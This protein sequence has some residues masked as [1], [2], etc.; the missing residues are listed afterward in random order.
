MKRYLT[1]EDGT[2]YEGQAFGGSSTSAGELV[3]TTG[4]TGYQETMTDDSYAGQLVI[5]TNPLLGNYGVSLADNEDLEPACAGVI[6]RQLARVTD[7]WRASESLDSFMQR[8][9]LPGISGI[10]TRELTQKLRTKGSM[11]ALITDEVLPAEKLPAELIQDQI[12]SFAAVKNQQ[13][14]YRIPGSGFTIVVVD[15]GAKQSILREL[16]KRDCNLVVVPSSSTAEQILSFA[17]DGVL[18]S[19]GPGDP[20]NYPDALPM[21][22]KIQ[23]KTVIFGICL[24]HQLFARANGAQTFKMKFGHRGFNHPVQEVAT[25]ETR[26]T[27]QNHGYAVDAA[28]LDQTLLTKTYV[29][30]NDQTVEGLRHKKFPAASVQ[31]HP[32]A[33][34]GPHDSVAVFDD[35]I[36][37]ITAQQEEKYAQKK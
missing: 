8:H 27:S 4:M 25:G 7:S 19:N 12:A 20:Q 10:D 23:E 28:S 9:N 14:P 34:P 2:V 16:I 36:A 37:M 24:G 5:F 11:R 30:L 1:L 35:F 15:F 26:F 18:L 22:Q 17:P 6:C 31:F 13:R 32:D 21:I 29:E 3:F 33:S